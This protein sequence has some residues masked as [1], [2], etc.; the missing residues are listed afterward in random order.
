MWIITKIEHSTSSKASG[1]G[2][3]YD[4]A[5][6]AY[7]ILNQTTQP[8]TE[9]VLCNATP[10]IRIGLG[11]AKNRPKSGVTP[12]Q[13]CAATVPALGCNLHGNGWSLTCRNAEH[14]VNMLYNPVA[15]PN[16]VVS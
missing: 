9:M 14:F 13:G 6:V 5:L 4:A 11:G 12:R 1:S 16:C 2:G 15:Y 7:V 3:F 8:T 10:S